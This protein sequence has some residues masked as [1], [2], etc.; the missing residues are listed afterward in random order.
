MNYGFF[1]VKFYVKTYRYVRYGYCVLSLILLVFKMLKIPKTNVEA[2]FLKKLDFVTNKCLAQDAFGK[3]P[4]TTEN[5]SKYAAIQ[6][7]QCIVMCTNFLIISYI[8]QWY[9]SKSAVLANEMHCP[10]KQSLS[11]L[12]NNLRDA[13]INAKKILQTL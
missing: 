1:S 2:D 5:L 11:Q 8:L 12:K 9:P 6:L 3:C 10:Y 4:K 13:F 7:S